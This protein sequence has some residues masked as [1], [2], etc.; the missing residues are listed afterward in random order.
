MIFPLYIIKAPFSGV[1]EARD[2]VLSKKCSVYLLRAGLFAGT[3]ELYT[4]M[5]YFLLFINS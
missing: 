5:S 2:N 1:R 4:L 3:V